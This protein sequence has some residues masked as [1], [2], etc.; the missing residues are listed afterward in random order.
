MVLTKGGP[1]NFEAEILLAPKAPKQNFGLSP[2]L[3]FPFHWL[4]VPTEPPDFPDSLLRVE[5]TRRRA[6]AL[7][8]GQGLC[9]WGGGGAGWN[10][11]LSASNIGRGGGGMRGSRGGGGKPPSSCVLRPFQYIPEVGSPLTVPRQ[12]WRTICTR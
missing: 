5:S 2:L 12:P 8:I 3:P 10:E 6:T 1:K 11:A 7:A 9:G 4:V